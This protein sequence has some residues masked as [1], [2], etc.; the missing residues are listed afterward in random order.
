M[1]KNIFWIQLLGKC[2]EPELDLDPDQVVK[3]PDPAIR[4][5]N[6]WIPN[7]AAQCLKNI[8]FLRCTLQI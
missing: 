8:K 7:T 2:T 1:V 3:I 4:S 5:G 6:D